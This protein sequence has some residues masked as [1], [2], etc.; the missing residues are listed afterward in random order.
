MAWLKGRIDIQT[1]RGIIDPLRDYEARIYIVDISTEAL[2][3]F[4]E[5]LDELD[6]VNEWLFSYPG[7]GE[8]SAPVKILIQQD[9]ARLNQL[10][11]QQD[12][13]T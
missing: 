2:E 5:I 1:W 8:Y 3:K 13:H 11:E 12:A 7:Y 4:A 9:R 6:P 10:R